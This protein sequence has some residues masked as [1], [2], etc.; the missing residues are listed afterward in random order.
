MTKQ[1]SYYDFIQR[2]YRETDLTDSDMTPLQKSFH[3]HVQYANSVLG[4]T[5]DVIGPIKHVNRFEVIDHINGN[6]NRN[7][8]YLRGCDSIQYSFQD[9]GRTLKIFISKDETDEFR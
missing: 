4:P 3:R 1:E 6:G 8:Y 5:D 7:V 2:K 9:D